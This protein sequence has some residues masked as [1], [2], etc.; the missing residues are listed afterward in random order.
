MDFDF[1]YAKIRVITYKCNSIVY[2]HCLKS[3]N[4]L[5]GKIKPVFLTGKNNS[6][7]RRYKAL[8]KESRLF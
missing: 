7:F 8:F 1:Q 6:S 4:T 3:I 2:F 5:Q